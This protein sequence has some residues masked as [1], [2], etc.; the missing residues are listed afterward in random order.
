[1]KAWEIVCFTYD[2]DIHCVDCT[3]LRFGPVTDDLQDSEGNPVH[4]MFASDEYEELVCGNCLTP[5]VET[6]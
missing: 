5:I 2:A 4:P 1:M 6:I 3:H